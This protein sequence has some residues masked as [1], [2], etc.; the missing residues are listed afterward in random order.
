M[1]I[2]GLTMYK[3]VWKN[4]FKSKGLRLN[5]KQC[6]KSFFTAIGLKQNINSINCFLNGTAMVKIVITVY[7]L[8]T[9]VVDRC[10]EGQ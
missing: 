7:K 10:T 2:E 6:F 8:F 1:D 3:K 9:V 5:V 4:G